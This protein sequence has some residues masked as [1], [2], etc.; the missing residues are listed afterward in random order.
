MRSSRWTV[1][2]GL[3]H[4]HVRAAPLP[5]R[6]EFVLMVLLGSSATEGGCRK[7]V[8]RPSAGPRTR[9]VDC[10]RSLAPMVPAGASGVAGGCRSLNTSVVACPGARHCVVNA[11]AGSSGSDV[12]TA[13]SRRDGGTGCPNFRC[14]HSRSQH[15]HSAALDGG[16]RIWPP[17]RPCAA[18]TVLAAL[19]GLEHRDRSPPDLV[20]PTPFGR[21]F[22]RTGL[23]RSS[24]G[25]CCSAWRHVTHGWSAPIPGNVGPDGAPWVGAGHRM[26]GV[27]IR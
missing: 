26:H 12:C 19:S 13:F 17:L 24:S 20:P 8:P 5:T 18:T 11:R 21:I 23:P 6:S 15:P 25:R 22:I 4:G 9:T 7:S 3:S 10:P 27:P 1:V 16:M 2:A 14:Q